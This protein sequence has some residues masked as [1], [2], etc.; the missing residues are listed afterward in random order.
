MRL[1]T[2]LNTLVISVLAFLTFLFVHTSP[3]KAATQENIPWF[4]T[5]SCMFELP[6]GAVEGKNLQCGYLHVPEEYENPEGATIQLAVAIIKA[7]DP[8]PQPDPLVMEQGG[9][10]GSTIH[11][12]ITQIFT[13]LT[14]LRTNR[15]II[16]LEQRG[17]LYSQPALTCPEILDETIRTLDQNLTVEESIKIS[18]EATLNCRDRLISESINLSAFDSIE[19]A[20]DINSLRVALGYDQINLYGVSY[21]TLLA[22]HVM[23]THPEGLRSVILDA[24]VPTQTN[25]ILESPQSQKRAFNRLF[26][27]CAADPDCNANYPHLEDLFWNTI[28]RLN[29]QPA[30]ITITDF[31]NRE[32]Y[33]AKLNGDWFRSSIFQMLYA[34]EIIPFLPRVIYE[35]SNGEFEFLQRI[36]SL[37]TIDKT[38]SYGMYYSVI[39]AEDADFTAADVNFDGLPPETAQYE[40]ENILSF[41]RICQQWN[42]QPLGV[43][44]D[45][46]VSSAIP[47][48]ILNGE[49]DPITPP[50]FGEEAAKTLKNSYV[51]NFPNGGHGAAMSGKCQDQIIQAFL[52]NPR[53]KPDTSCVDQETSLQFMSQTNTILLPVL[54]KLMNLEGIETAEFVILSI[55][56]LF[57]LTAP[58][59]WFVFW[60]VRK[61]TGKLILPR[62][63]AAIFFRWTATINAAFLALFLGILIFISFKL[64]LNN[65][66]TILYGLPSSTKL[67]FIFPLATIITTAL[68]AIG[69]LLA[70]R[71]GY[72]S[73]WNRL[74]YS[75]LTLLACA[76]SLIL[77]LWNMMG[78]IFR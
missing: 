46:P 26:S 22:L 8:N 37:L 13:G 11:T 49:Y 31:D 62:S 24:V 15:D 55:S 68:M 63:R 18:E 20:A 48:L 74:Y 59:V 58:P 5:T 2:F 65:D 23:Q 66:L 61:L 1:T 28:A 27:T 12:Y 67:L 40:K 70:W 72:W 42:V 3:V 9:P 21:G 38:M 50:Y 29:E 76:S 35:A 32:T 78:V 56:I 77:S 6:P 7:K 44:A 41:L 64:A 25:F 51:V 73:I 57:M 75:L 43:S 36:L 47:T 10:G 4:E 19:N 33:P 30:E 60:V 69:A 39:C 17:T 16:L 54:G 14:G 52:D 71:R 53:T 34:T 45:L